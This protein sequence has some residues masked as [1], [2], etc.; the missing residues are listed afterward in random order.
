M[1]CFRWSHMSSTR[2]VCN[3]RKQQLQ[4]GEK[5]ANSY[6]TALWEVMFRSFSSAFSFYLLNSP[7]WY[8]CL[9]FIAK[10]TDAQ[11][12]WVT[13]PRAESRTGP[14]Q[15]RIKPGFKSRSS[16]LWSALSI[17]LSFSIRGHPIRSG[18]GEGGC[19]SWAM[20]WSRE[21]KRQR[22]KNISPTVIIN[23]QVE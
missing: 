16:C 12:C 17:R 11:L 23:T 15:P 4:R 1:E 13:C 2:N 8:H 14:V 19:G 21:S 7:T 9:H 3:P 22:Q 6:W 10:E 5:G 18:S 20:K